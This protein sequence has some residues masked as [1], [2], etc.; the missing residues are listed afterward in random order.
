MGEPL[1][2]DVVDLQAGGGEVISQNAARLRCRA[3]TS[4][5]V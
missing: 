2:V 4:A 5:S 3:A 1:D